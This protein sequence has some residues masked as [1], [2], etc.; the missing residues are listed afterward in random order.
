MATLPSL[1][2]ISD[3]P[4]YS[5]VSPTTG[6]ILYTEQGVDYKLGVSTLATYSTLSLADGEK[7]LGKCP[8]IAQLRTIEPTIDNQS[9]TVIRAVPGGPIINS[10]LT[11]DQTDTTT[12]DNDFSVFVTAGGAR[13]KSDSTYGH[14]VFLAGYDPTK[15]NLHSCIN[16][17]NQWYVTKAIS[18]VQINNRKA[19]ILVPMLSDTGTTY[20]ITGTIYLAPSLVELR[21][22]GDMLFDC[23]SLTTTD[24]IVLS[25]E[26]AGLTSGMGNSKNGGSADAGGYVINPQG[27]LF[28][29]GAGVTSVTD[30]SGTITAT[31]NTSGVGIVFGN[32]TRTSSN[33]AYLNVRDAKI[34][35]VRVWGFTGGIQFGNY[36]T[37]LCTVEDSN[38]YDNLHNHYQ[39]NLTCTNSGEGLRLINVVLSNAVLNNSYI[40]TNGHDYWFDKTHIDYAAQDGISF[41]P[42]AVSELILSDC[43]VEGNYRWVFGQPTKTGT[44][45]QCRVLM[46]GGKIVPNR[47][48][49]TY[50]GVRPIFKSVVYNTFI[51]ELM[52]VDLNGA[53]AG[54]MCNDAYGSWCGL[55][56][57]TI[58]V[59]DYRLSDTY[60]WLP[61][62]KYGVG[63]YLL[64]SSYTWTGTAGSTPPTSVSTVTA[65][66][67]YHWAFVSGGGSIV[68]GASSDADADGLIPL[69][70][71]ATATTDIAYL[72]CANY[73]QFP[74]NGL[75]LSAKCAVK[76]AS[77]T[78]NVTVQA[79]LRP[80]TYQSIGS[81][82]NT[83]TNAI[84]N[85]ATETS[86]GLVTG[87][88]VD[89]LTGIIGK[90]YLTVTAANYVSTPPLK[91]NNYYLGSIWGNAGLRFTGFT[92]T[93]YIKLPAYWFNTLPPN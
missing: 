47:Y 63:G 87:D 91:V 2:K 27:L 86:R 31:P 62:Y 20:T 57:Q 85:I 44:S 49:V 9:I 34:K 89:V 43:W 59:V 93:I 73:F 26:Y 41:G 39:P 56:D 75:Y 25:H 21:P 51:V 52:K 69:A 5:S 29:A 60:K 10:T 92:G 8:T 28:I 17:I 66:S 4:T 64:N 80:L 68:Y 18:D 33:G 7:Y 24:A 1:K 67:A 78:D 19:I 55:G 48:G 42:N 45:G 61:N 23:S 22:M 90:S 74:R 6:T 3:L 71:T 72:Y 12:A 38:F 76:C 79:V 14:N 15:N 88:S 54:Y 70:I 65:D 81:T 82:L 40:D 77:A 32:R 83:T 84:T 50:R 53:Y 35:N 36:D 30:S 16:K 58:L 37:Y 46:Q 13:W 11:Y